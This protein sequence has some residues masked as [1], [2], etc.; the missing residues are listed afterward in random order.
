MPWVVQSKGQW[1]LKPNWF[2]LTMHCKELVVP[3]DPVVIVQWCQVLSELWLFSFSLNRFILCSN[4]FPV[5]WTTL[6][7]LGHDSFQSWRTGICTTLTLS[8]TLVH[9]PPIPLMMHQSVLSKFTTG[10]LGP[11]CH[12]KLALKTRLKVH[13]PPIW[14]PLNTVCNLTSQIKRFAH[15]SRRHSFFD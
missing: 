1:L 15:N 11:K 14:F 10:S 2:Q 3:S 6:A 9:C 7:C 4:K 12:S 13:V 5:L 8:Q